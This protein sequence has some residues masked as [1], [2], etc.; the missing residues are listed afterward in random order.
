[1]TDRVWIT[2]KGEQ[3]HPDGTVEKN[4]SRQQADYR[5]LEDGT[6]ELRF[7][8]T[9]EGYGKTI[10]NRIT[11]SEK[12]ITVEKTGNFNTNL[13]LEAGHLNSCG[14]D[15]EFGMIPM[16]IQTQQVSLLTVDTNIHAQA[17]YELDMGND[18]KVECKVSIKI[19]PV[20]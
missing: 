8:E 1:V 13:V 11:V 3:T 19:E 4:K 9:L 20:V 2:I 16:D 18:Y 17:R 5:L 10:P 14:Y 15:T 12:C 6:H 7:E